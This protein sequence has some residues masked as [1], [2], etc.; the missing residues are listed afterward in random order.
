M[1]AGHVRGI[2]ATWYGARAGCPMSTAISGD[3]RK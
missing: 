1:I 3:P 2:G